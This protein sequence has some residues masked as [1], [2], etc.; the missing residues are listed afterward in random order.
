MGMIFMWPVNFTPSGFALCDGTLMQIQQNNAL[1]AILGTRYG[2]NGTTTFGLPDL[3]NRVPRGLNVVDGPTALG[4][5]DTY[6]GNATGAVNIALTAANLPSHNHTTGGGTLSISIPVSTDNTANTDTPGPTTVLT[7]GNVT[8]GLNTTPTK[9]Y[10]TVA[11]STTLLPFNATLPAGTTGNT[12][13]GTPLAAPVVVPLLIP[14]LP[15]YCPLN[16]IIATQ[17]IFPTRN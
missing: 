12:G 11:A 3:R 10:T 9:Q 13:T 7:R 16:F 14:T 8:A 6:G 17:G 1:Y 4:G 5:S 2:G 15:A